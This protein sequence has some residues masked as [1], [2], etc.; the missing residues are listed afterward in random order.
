MLRGVRQR[1]SGWAGVWLL[2]GLLLGGAAGA[3]TVWIMKRDKPGIPGSPRLGQAE[4]LALVPG[5]AV[6]FVHI[7]AR[8]IWKTEFL[9]DF[10]KIIE[11]AG[12]ENLSL[13]EEEFFARPSALDRVTLVALVAG[14]DPLKDA[15][16]SRP[17]PPPTPNIPKGPKTQDGQPK[18]QDA[19]KQPF[20]PILP[21]MPDPSQS[22]VS[23]PEHIELVA[24]LAFTEQ[25]DA[26][27]VRSS[28]LP[29]AEQPVSGIEHWNDKNRNTAAYF[30][31]DKIL[32]IGT[33]AGV[34]QFVGRQSAEAKKQDLPLNA[35][36]DFAAGG[37][38][39]F[40][41]AVNAQAFHVNLLR[42]TSEFR[43]LLLS[44]NEL[45]QLAEDAKP[46]LRAEAFAVGLG[47]MGQDDSKFDVRVYF[48]QEDHAVEGEK[49]VRTLS[50][51][52]HKKLEES[53]K[54]FE[55]TLKGPADKT[56]PRP[57]SDYPELVK[58]LFNIG[59]IEKADTYLT[60]PPLKRD[61]KELDATFEIS[62]ISTAYLAATFVEFGTQDIVVQKL[63]EALV[64]K[65]K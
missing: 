50:E 53:K 38:C 21:N 62:A 27:K 42:L 58:S 52:A 47:L 9:A 28:L 4:E 5:D 24:I 64:K 40:V 48:K 14:R 57:L 18:L 43:S 55:M 16:L 46:L 37:K 31:S 1:T 12:P 13:F 15:D 22:L 3:A 19:P 51:F 17:P 33:S 2:I 32:V 20:R 39:H 34:R 23:G 25:Y 7:R 44:Q 63:R 11:K 26:A 56:K 65:Q 49:S 41:A 60:N 59:S 35:A 54:K 30:P 45:N 29:D 36:L 6:G 61:G 10:R 8:D